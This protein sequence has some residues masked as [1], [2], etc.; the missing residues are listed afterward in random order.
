MRNDQTSHIFVGRKQCVPFSR[1]CIG[2]KGAK[3]NNTFISISRL[4]LLDGESQIK[5]LKLCDKGVLDTAETYKNEN[6]HKQSK[7]FNDVAQNLPSHIHYFK[8][9]NTK[10]KI[11]LLQVINNI[12]RPLK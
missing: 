4:I 9:H 11:P 10:V 1:H 5:G 6:I 12:L 3:C 2:I 7:L 8:T